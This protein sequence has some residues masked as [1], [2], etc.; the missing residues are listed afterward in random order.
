MY[1]LDFLKLNLYAREKFHC[2]T[3]QQLCKNISFIKDIMDNNSR[4][5]NSKFFYVIYFSLY[6]KNISI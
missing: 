5:K 3:V 1:I 4:V 2:S 6:N